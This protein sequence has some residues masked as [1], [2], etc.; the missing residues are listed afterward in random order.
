[1]HTEG[2]RTQALLPSAIR[3][4]PNRIEAY[5]WPLASRPLRGARRSLAGGQAAAPHAESSLQTCTYKPEA[6]RR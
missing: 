4:A 1:V 3:L 2:L 5:D 6:R